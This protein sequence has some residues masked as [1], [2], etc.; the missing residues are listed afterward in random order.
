[1]LGLGKTAC[2]H[3]ALRKNQ[4]REVKEAELNRLTILLV[5][6]TKGCALLLY[7]VLVSE[8]GSIR[9]LCWCTTERERFMATAQSCTLKR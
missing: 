8:S 3:V 4:C 5:I 2:S 1:M 6:Y 7:R 9:E